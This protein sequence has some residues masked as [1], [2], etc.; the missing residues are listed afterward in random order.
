[1]QEIV[2]EEEEEQKGHLRRVVA[3]QEKLKHPPRLGKH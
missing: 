2:K 3:K 1:M